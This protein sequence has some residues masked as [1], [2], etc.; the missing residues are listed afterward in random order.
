M[1]TEQ[2]IANQVKEKQADNEMLR[3]EVDQKMTRLMNLRDTLPQEVI[4]N[5][6]TMRIKFSFCLFVCL[7]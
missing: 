7:L 4:D 3:R 1:E 6:T 5:K 2:Q